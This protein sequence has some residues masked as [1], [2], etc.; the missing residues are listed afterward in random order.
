MR[1]VEIMLTD[2]D[3]EEVPAIMAACEKCEVSTFVVFIITGKNH[4]HLQCTG[5]RQAYC[6]GGYCEN[7]VGETEEVKPHGINREDFSSRPLFAGATARHLGG[8]VQDE[9][10]PGQSLAPAAVRKKPEYNPN[11]W[12]LTKPD[13]TRDSMITKDAMPRPGKKGKKADVLFQ[14]LRD[15]DWHTVKECYDYVKAHYPGKSVKRRSFGQRGLDRYIEVII[16]GERKDMSDIW[17]RL[18]KRHCP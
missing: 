17:L 4:S 15:R 14:L 6:P 13:G 2:D 5:C 3:G 9:S 16:V 8:E 7:L 1:E 12:L 10:P 18:G 11:H